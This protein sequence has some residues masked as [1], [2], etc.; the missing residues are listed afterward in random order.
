MRSII[1]MVSISLES[2]LLSIL[3]LVVVIVAVILVVVVIDAIVG[4]VIVVICALVSGPLVCE[5]CWWLPLESEVERMHSTKTRHHRSRSFSWSRVSIKIVGICHGSNL[6][7][8]GFINTLCNQLSNGSLGHSW[9][10]WKEFK[11]LRERH[12]N[13]GMSDPI[14][15]NLTGDEDPFD[16]DGGAGIGDST[17]VLVSLVN[18]TGD[19]DPFD[20]DGGAGIGDSTGVL[21]SLGEIS[22]EG[23]K[24]WES[25]I[26]DSDNTGDGGKIAGEQTSMS[27]R[28]LVKSFEEP[29]EMFSGKITV[30]I[31]VKDRCPR[32]KGC[33]SSLWCR[34]W[35]REKERDVAIL[36]T[37]K[38][39]RGSCKK[40]VGEGGC[41]TT[42]D[43]RDSLEGTNVSEGDQD[44]QAAEIIALKARIKKLEKK[45]KPN[46]SHHRARLKSVQRL[47][48]KKRFRKKESVSKQGRKK[49]KP[50]PT[51]DDSTFGGLDVDHGMGSGKKEG[52]TKELVSTA[53]P[54]DNTIRPD[55]GTA[56][57]IALLRT[58]TSIFDDEDITMAQTLIKIKEEKA[59]EKGDKGKDAEVARLVYEE[60]L[61]EL[62][63][64]KEKRQRE[65]EAYKAAIAE[66]YDEV[67][68]R[69]EADALFIAKLQ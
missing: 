16:E 40:L 13:N 10:Q 22:L 57:P 18:L 66:M 41:Y 12:E 27:K 39:N 15:V 45:C 37:K 46:I 3:L 51:L 38:W 20:E 4:V 47:S 36:K 24:S 31:L 67:Q 14:G 65:E 42:Q 32:R 62:E 2:F 54:E 6:C 1:S 48:M 30:V 58:K 44:A 28:Y 29:G 69:I 50:E 19:E 35:I 59:K 5:I 21:V 33:G 26:G 9:V 55:V 64:E 60:E 11:T 7:F 52:S 17:G 25:N 61:A 43:F 23:N 49:D 56:D 53:R 68:A 8:Q 63:R 34:N